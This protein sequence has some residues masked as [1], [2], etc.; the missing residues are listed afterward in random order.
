MSMNNDTE[1]KTDRTTMSTWA[2][3]AEEQIARMGEMMEQG[4]RIQS[5]AMAQGKEM[6]AYNM[7]LASDWQSWAEETRRSVEERF[8]S[9]G[10]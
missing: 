7:K 5:A 9:R 2:R 6:I 10:K 4:K 1:A 8:V 3:T